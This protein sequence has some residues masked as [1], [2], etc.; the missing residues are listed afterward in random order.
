MGMTY[1]G[2]LRSEEKKFS[3]LKSF[4]RKSIMQ[5]LEH[6]NLFSI[7]PVLDFLNWFMQQIAVE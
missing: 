6:D 1:Q 2:I 7:S 5:R 4:F 3:K